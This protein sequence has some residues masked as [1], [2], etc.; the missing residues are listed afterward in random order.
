MTKSSIF[1]EHSGRKVALRQVHEAMS[2]AKYDVNEQEQTLKVSNLANMDQFHYLH[3]LRHPSI[4]LLH[5]I[6]FQEKEVIYRWPHQQPLTSLRN[7][8]IDEDT[9]G[10]KFVAQLISAMKHMHMRYLVMRD[11]NPDTIVVCGETAV[12][13]NFEH[14]C[15]V[16][17]SFH[18]VHTRESHPFYRPGVYARISSEK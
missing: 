16:H 3:M 5:N 1:C 6:A 8:A 11:I 18:D 2:K 14:S 13:I 17:G 12:F 7:S 9:F 4:P 10:T 15:I